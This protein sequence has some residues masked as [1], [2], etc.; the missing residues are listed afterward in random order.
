MV[1]HIAL[2]FVGASCDYRPI[3]LLK[4]EQRSASYLEKSPRGKVPLLDVGKFQVSENIAILHWLNEEFAEAQ[5]LPVADQKSRAQLNSDLAWFASGIHPILTRTI[6]PGRF[7]HSEPCTT[8]VRELAASALAVELGILNERL[9]DRQWLYEKWSAADAYI[10][11][12]WQR[13]GEALANKTAFGAITSHAA[14]M[15]ALPPVQ[16]ALRR[17]AETFAVQNRPL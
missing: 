1:S 11:W 6:F 10:F 17:E 2:E 7:V 13:A 15:G 16:R 14:R 3:N 5:L 12:I 9:K 4:G 8:G